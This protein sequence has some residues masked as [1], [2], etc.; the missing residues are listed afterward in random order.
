MLSQ[1]NS[2]SIRRRLSILI[3]GISAV[4][5]G[6]V[7]VIALL[8][9]TFT[10]Q[11]AAQ[12][13]LQNRSRTMATD[14]DSR[15][16]DVSFVVNR[17]G[18]R[19]TFDDGS[20]DQDALT[21]AIVSITG[22]AANQPTT[23]LIQRIF[24]Y[25]P[26]DGIFIYSF[27]APEARIARDN[28][29][30][31]SADAWFRTT[32]EQPTNWRG[33]ESSLFAPN[34]P[35]ITYFVT[36]NTDDASVPGMLWA[37][38]N[39]S[40]TNAILRDTVAVEGITTSADSGYSFLLANNG[41]VAAT[42]NLRRRT[43][44]LNA[45]ISTIG[46]YTDN[47]LSLP[48]GLTVNDTSTSPAFAIVSEMPLTGWR[49]V[50]VLPTSVLPAIPLQTLFVV[51]LISVMG[52]AAL[53][54]VTNRF[55]RVVVIDPV[56]GLGEIAARIGAGD[57]RQQISYRQQYDEI[58]QLAR[59]L[60]EMR[61]NLQQSYDTLETRV[62]AR[63]AELENAQLTAQTSMSELRAVY[64]E[65]ISVV[66]DYQLKAILNK[67][68]QRVLTML[69]GAYCGVWLLRSNGK[70]LRLIA[71]TSL[72]DSLTGTTINLGE[73]LVGLTLQQAR[74][75]TMNN[76]YKHTNRLNLSNSDS[77]AR[78]LCVPLISAGE[79][80]G[81]VI[82]GRR[83]DQAIFT[84]R[85]E[86]LLTLFANLVAPSVRNAQLYAELDTARLSADRANEVKTRFLASVTHELR[87]PL[88]LIINNMDFMRVGAFGSVTDEQGNRLDQAI[89]S[90]EHLLYLI[91]DLLDVS[92]I[93]AGEMQL[94]IQKQ[95]IHPVIEDA[96]DSTVVLLDKGDKGAKVAL[97]AHI[98]EDLPPVPM[99]ARRVR[100]VLFNLL[101]N[102]VK[103]TE[104]GEVELIVELNSDHVRF[105][106][107]DTGLGIPEEE[108]EMLFEPFE[109]ANSARH[110][111]IEGTGLGLPICKFLVE[112]HGGQLNYM[113]QVGVGTTFW[114][115]L[116]LTSALIDSKTTTQIMQIISRKRRETQESS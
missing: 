61:T 12:S 46:D 11:A 112:E 101:S 39:E 1:V 95:E 106:V 34:V 16:Q 66:S 104:E 62:H 38:I 114:F 43:D 108:R 49:L 31:Y 54:Y 44:D 115:T 33:I 97:S 56:E 98:P 71:H 8:G 113:S 42:A 77:V 99:D 80:I 14:L 91:N 82:V 57:M 27:P 23:A 81:S 88:N 25:T 58:G 72:D 53:I 83:Q 84:D 26:V 102:A 3:V 110:L 28:P 87:T 76:Y 68:T 13:S 47:V 41:Q 103:F 64:D 32:Q 24:L 74:P 5:L 45:T 10:L 60:E 35:V 94:F 40:T 50:T 70:Q 30:E 93:E 4:T 78:A 92:K 19:I 2:L 107:R 59:A 52:I 20:V 22:L 18:D 85:S 65:S 37:E 48:H 55:L 109:R 100:Q 63:T 17:I 21:D 6:A 105:E 90:A 29:D 36:I 7:S 15:L 96:L 86:R 69:D 116:P 9:S 89:R 67:F 79:A 75:F 73:G 51:I 111:A